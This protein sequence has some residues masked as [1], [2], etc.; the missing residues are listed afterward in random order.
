[1][2][3]A[4]AD[5][6]EI[7]RNTWKM[8]ERIELVA[9]GVVEGLDR[10]LLLLLVGAEECRE[11]QRRGGQQKGLRKHFELMKTSTGRLN[12]SIGLPRQ[13]E[14]RQRERCDFFLIWAFP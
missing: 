14:D 1:V 7:R 10:L 4:E 2:L 3:E 12:R 5:G 6:I 9:L 11:R 13:A 8:Q